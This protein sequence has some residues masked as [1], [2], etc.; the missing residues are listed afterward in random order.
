M[1]ASFL[2]GVPWRVVGDAGGADAGA[3]IVGGAK[4]VG[5][6]WPIGDEIDPRPLLKA[7]DEAGWRCAL[8]VVVKVGSPLCFRAWRPGDALEPGAH[9]IPA[10]LAA[11]AMVTPTLLLVPLLAFDRSGHRLGYGGGYYDRTLAALRGAGALLAVGLAYAG[12][13]LAAVPTAG[14]DVAL[15]WVVTECEAIRI[16]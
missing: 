9:A 3:K 2:D 5:G 4:A 7:L 6:Y 1:A 8:P 15:D 11:A 13:E 10:P 16:G 14:D 12:Q